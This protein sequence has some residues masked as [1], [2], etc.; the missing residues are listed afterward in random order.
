MQNPKTLSAAH[1]DVQTAPNPPRLGE[2]ILNVKDVCR[3]FNKSQG[4]LLVL[5]DANVSR[6]HA[7]IERVG[8]VWYL[9]DLGSTNGCYIEGQRV[10]RRAI[11][12]GD[13]IEITTHQIRCTLS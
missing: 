3:G 4:E 12:D 6:Q 10:S 7:A 9:A 5:D 11:S 8:D 13:V 2:E 1:G